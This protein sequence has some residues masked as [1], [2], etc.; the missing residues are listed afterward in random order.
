MSFE[1]EL[2]A[3]ISRRRSENWVCSGFDEGGDERNDAMDWWRITEV[4]LN[5]EER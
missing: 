1:V 3:G 4:E 5:W 2:V